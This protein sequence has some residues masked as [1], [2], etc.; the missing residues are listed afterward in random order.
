M[1]TKPDV[2]HRTLVNVVA[3]T[4]GLSDEGPPA[5]NCGWCY[6]AV[7]SFELDGCITSE[8]TDSDHWQ[9]VKFGDL[10]HIGRKLISNEPQAW[11]QQAVIPTTFREGKAESA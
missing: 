1:H 7:L 8:W 2:G 3:K 9:M 6:P 10:I 11:V 5:V 4:V